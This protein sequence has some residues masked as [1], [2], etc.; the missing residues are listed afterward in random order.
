MRKCIL[1]WRYLRR[2]KEA[3]A[4]KP[5]MPPTENKYHLPCRPRR[6]T[7]PGDDCSCLQDT[8]HF[9]APQRL[10]H[11]LSVSTHLFIHSS[12]I[13]SVPLPLSSSR[14]NPR[15]MG[16][17]FYPHGA[18]GERQPSKKEYD[19]GLPVCDSQKHEEG[20]PPSLDM[21]EGE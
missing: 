19:L 3:V 12:T 2:F 7:L 6:A 17:S 13:F 4:M 15:R 1:P 10:L 18:L 16:H 5:E 11:W 14:N 9:G 20:T 21:G 8:Q